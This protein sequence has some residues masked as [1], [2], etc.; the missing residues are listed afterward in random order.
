M[1]DSKKKPT[2]DIFRVMEQIDKRN[3]NFYKTLTDEEKKA[4]SPLVIMRWISAVKGS[5][6]INEYY[7][8]MVN[9]MI[10]RNLWDPCLSKHPELLYMLLAQCGI[11][12]KVNHEWIK[13]FSRE[14]KTKLNNFLKQYYPTA[15]NSELDFLVSINSKEQLISMVEESGLQ[16][17][18]AKVLIKE[19]KELKK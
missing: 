14:K 7:I 15:S 9:E 2:L 18:E 1:A 3:F 11:G 8:Q 19:I 16:D 10:N 4:F 5:R 17:D 13:G 12:Q 6:E